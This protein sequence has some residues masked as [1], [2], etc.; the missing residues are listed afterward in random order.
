MDRDVEH[1]I[2]EDDDA[3]RLAQRLAQEFMVDRRLV[4]GILPQ[5]LPMLDVWVHGLPLD[6]PRPYERDLDRDVVEVLRPGAQD[7]LHLRAAL[8]L[9]AADGV[10]ALD[11]LEDIRI[12]EPHT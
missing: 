10:C 3:E 4:I 5:L 2:L 12:V 8:D 1:L 7:R 11:L 9:E 6:W